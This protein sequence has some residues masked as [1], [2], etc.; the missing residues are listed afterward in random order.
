MRGW[1]ELGQWLLNLINAA[2]P[3]SLPQCFLAD[4]EHS[5]FFHCGAVAFTLNT[6]PESHFCIKCHRSTSLY[7]SHLRK[8]ASLSLFSLFFNHL[9][10]L[11][12]L[13]LSLPPLP[14]SISHFQD[15]SILFL[16][17]F[18]LTLLTS[19]ISHLEALPVRPLH[20]FH[21]S[22]IVFLPL[23]SPALSRY[24][25]ISLVALP[26]FHHSSR[27]EPGRWCLPPRRGKKGEK[28]HFL[29]YCHVSEI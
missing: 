11:T 15:A 21:S 1:L 26:S 23:I 27:W 19:P 20:L 13:H 6:L 18:P 17:H 25:S 12:P 9:F 5:V 29:S 24:L 2:L 8:K 4:Y 7:L 22:P 14:S 3:D 16:K 10:Y 28:K